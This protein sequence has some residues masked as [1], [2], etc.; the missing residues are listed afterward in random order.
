MCGI[1]GILLSP[2]YSGPS[3]LDALPAMLETLQHRGP[4][5]GGVWLDRAAGIGLG[6]RRLAIVDLSDSGRQPMH[7]PDG[8]LVASY[9]GEI[10]N[11]R[12]LRAELEARGHTFRGSGDTEVMLAAFGCFGIEAAL[13]RF[14]GMFAIAVWDRAKNEL[15]LIR[16]RLGKKPLYV[17][18]I[19]GALVFASE[20][21][22]LRAF[23]LFN[24]AIDPAA[25]TMLLRYGWI[26]DHLCIW[27]GVFKLPPGTRLTVSA[28]DLTTNSVEHL[29]SLIKP[30]WSLEEMA[31]AGVAAPLPDDDA[32]LVSQLDRLLRTAVRQRMLADVPLGALLSGGI[33]STTVVALMQAQSADPIRTF[34]IGFAESGY[35]EAVHSERVAHHLGTDHITLRVSPAEA[36]AII[37]ELPSVW[38]EPFADE[39]QIPTLLVARLARRYV[40]VALSGD[41]GDECFGGYRRHVAAARLRAIF[42]LPRPLRASGGAAL[43]LL[44]ACSGGRFLRAMPTWASVRRSLAGRDLEKLAA[45]LSARDEASL[46]RNLLSVTCH[47]AVAS[48]RPVFERVDAFAADL[49]G[50][51][52]YRDLSRYLPGDV[53]VKVDRASMAVSLEVRCPLLDHRIVEFALRLPAHTKVRGPVSKWLLRQVLRRYVPDALFA[54]PKAGFDVPIGAWL[55]GP[56]RPWAEDVLSTARHVNDGALDHRRVAEVWREHLTGRRDCGHELW[57]ILMFQAWRATQSS[58]PATTRQAFI[59]GAA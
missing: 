45:L 43:R 16:D 28:N 5:G 40:K 18:M 8:A 37:P 29:R 33:D 58:G 47:P 27:E 42:G 32:E 7:A 35:D 19:K 30:W 41:G 54:R 26:P 36:Q 38:D 24:A 46:Y 6:H 59:A 21:R 50:R 3:G 20:L 48:S 51:L 57:A 10:Y 53:L 56:L 23:P 31:K 22:A 39:S 34:T 9:N 14:A 55:A 17:T 44:R 12:E 2:S 52:M 11:F 15:H 13:R 1:T 25:V 4:D 49:P